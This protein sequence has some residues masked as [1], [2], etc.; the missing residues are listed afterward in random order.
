M[1]VQLETEG[2]ALL[3]AFLVVQLPIPEAV[4][5]VRLAMLLVL[6]VLEVVEMEFLALLLRV[7]L[8]QQTLAAAAVV[9]LM[10]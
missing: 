9:H 4:V 5:D 2:L 1:E 7:M 3:Q 6:V 8:E 10:G